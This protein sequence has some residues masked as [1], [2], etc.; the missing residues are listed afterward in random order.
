MSKLSIILASSCIFLLAVTASGAG[1]NDPDQPKFL[2]GLGFAAGH[3]SGV[4]MSYK[5]V[6]NSKYAVQATFG[7]YSDVDYGD[8][9]AMPGVEFQ[10]HISRNENTSFYLSTGISY[11]YYRSEYYYWYE[12]DVDDWDYET[13]YDIDKIWTTGLGFGFE[14]LVFER[15]S[16]TVESILYYRDNERASIMVQGGI[17]YYFNMSSGEE[18]EPEWPSS[19]QAP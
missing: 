12:F 3:Y 7:Y 19:I 9:W 10:Y 15:I 2:Q 16:V 13:K 14:A 4:G 18:P 5:L 8:R 6:Y 17:H 1:L 11:E